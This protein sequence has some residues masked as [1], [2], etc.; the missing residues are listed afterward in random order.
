M[1]SYRNRAG[2]IIKGSSATAKLLN[3]QEIQGIVRVVSRS[4]DKTT[5]TFRVEIES[6]NAD[7]SIS[8]GQTA[9]ISIASDGTQAHLLP[10]SALTLDDSGTLGVRTVNEKSQ[11]VFFATDLIRDTTKGVWLKG[12]P[13]KATV[14]VLGQEYVTDGVE[15]QQFFKRLKIDRNYRLGLSTC[16]NDFG[17]N[18]CITNCRIFS[19]LG[20]LKKESPISRFQL[21][22]FPWYSWYFSS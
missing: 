2:R 21:Y 11:V 4:A 6:D 10:Q 7:L 5:R 14:I 15:V 18:H 16:Q 12:L 1:A 8:K 19:T 3:G 22:L 13:E 9:E 20:F 17:T